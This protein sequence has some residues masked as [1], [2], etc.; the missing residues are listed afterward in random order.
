[1]HNAFHCAKCTE[2]CHRSLC[3]YFSQTLKNKRRR[4][5]KFG[6]AALFPRFT[7]KRIL[8]SIQQSLQIAKK[9]VQIFSRLQYATGQSTSSRAV[10]FLRSGLERCSQR[11]NLMGVGVPI[12][13]K[14]LV[15]SKCPTAQQRRET[16]ES[17][18]GCPT[19]G[20]RTQIKPLEP[21]FYIA[22]PKR[23]CYT[24][25]TIPCCRER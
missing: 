18:V 4:Q 23:L 5:N 17:V 24:P 1:M 3:N 14:A 8:C 15:Y 10:P 22:I 20:L 7:T 11:G 9:H 2:T 16:K 21:G 13:L 12:I 6:V 19:V 25:L